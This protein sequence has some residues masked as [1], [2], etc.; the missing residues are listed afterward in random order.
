MA[1]FV[2]QQQ[3]Q[4]VATEIISFTKTYYPALAENY[5]TSVPGNFGGHLGIAL[6]WNGLIT[7]SG[8]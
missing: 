6:T 1:A 8:Q 7:E 2:L 4:V 3:S 5:A